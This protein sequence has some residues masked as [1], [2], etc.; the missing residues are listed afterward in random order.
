MDAPSGVSP[1]RGTEAALLAR[2]GNQAIVA[3]GVAVDAEEPVR[4]HAAAEEG[5]KL[6]LDETRRWMFP[7]RRTGEEAFQLL[8]HDLVKE[9]LLRFMA[10]VLGHE[11]PDWDQGWNAADEASARSPSGQPAACPAACPCAGSARSR[12]ALPRECP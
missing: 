6:L 2:E 3:T 8:A 9:G 4:E 12:P 1:A 7:E 10:L 11:V 5:A